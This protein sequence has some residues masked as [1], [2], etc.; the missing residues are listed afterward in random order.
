MVRTTR[1]DALAGP[2]RVWPAL[3]ASGAGVAA[4]LLGAS[5]TACQSANP[6]PDR[7]KPSTA[8]VSRPTTKTP[9]PPVKIE[10]TDQ[11]VNDFLKESENKLPVDLVNFSGER[12]AAVDWTS[13]NHA[14]VSEISQKT[15]G[16]VQL[17]SLEIL[18]LC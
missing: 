7:P 14:L 9:A 15:G 8:S 12:Y 4:L 16:L 17:Q 1:K 2:R 10:I 18:G 11:M 5:L 13:D 6:G 3:E